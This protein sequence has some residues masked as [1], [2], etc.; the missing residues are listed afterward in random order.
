MTNIY[1]VGRNYALHAKELQND[2]PTA[3]FLFLKPTHALVCGDDREI[4]LPG[5]KGDLHYEAELVIHIG[6]EYE[7]GM[8]VDE[9]VDQMTIGIDF[10][11]RDVQ[12]EC[13]K[14]GKPWLQAKGFKNSAL[15]GSFIPFPG[16]EECKKTFFSLEKNDQTVQ[17]GCIKNMIFTLQ[18]IIDF[19][20]LHYGIGRGDLIFTG[21]PEGVGA[22][23]NGDTL[24]LFWGDQELGSS[25]VR[26]KG[27]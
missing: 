3:P 9:V 10:T 5:G 15:V 21:T 19:T 22:V 16:E 8:T 1:C 7:K 2:I 24:R 23:Q 11:L 12:T 13:K 25:H 27:K 20:G 26:V 18:E 14:Q 6:K 17:N 4:V